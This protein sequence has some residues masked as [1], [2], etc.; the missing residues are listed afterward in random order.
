MHQSGA[1][2]N[3]AIRVDS[4]LRPGGLSVGR[5]AKSYRLKLEGYRLKP[6]RKLKS[7]RLK[8]E[9]KGLSVESGTSTD[10]TDSPLR[11]GFSR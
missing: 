9:R 6:E 1:G 8:L 5:D 3:L 11:S 2:G 10:S 4:P 7:Y